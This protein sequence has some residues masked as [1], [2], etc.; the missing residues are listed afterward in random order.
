MKVARDP[1]SLMSAA[2]IAA[3]SMFTPMGWA[4][5]AAVMSGLVIPV[6]YDEA[7]NVKIQLIAGFAKIKAG[8]PVYIKDLTVEYLDG[9]EVEMTVTA[10]ECLYFREN[11]AAR[12]KSHV[13]IERENLIVT[14]QDFKWDADKEVFQIFQDARV[15]LRNVNSKDRLSKK[16]AEETQSE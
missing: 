7:G 12:S 6:K 13:K 4:E 5:E 1:I 8:A 16:K 14:G 10:P 9:E 3:F 15:E 11:K 2:C